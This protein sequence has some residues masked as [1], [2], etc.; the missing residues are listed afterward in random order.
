MHGKAEAE[1]NQYGKTSIT[2]AELEKYKAGTEM[3][4]QSFNWKDFI[5]KKNS[6]LN[7]VNLNMTGG[8]DKINYYIS[9]THLQPE[10]GAG[11][12]IYIQENQHSE[13]C[14]C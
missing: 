7:S 13:Q 12:G 10:L 3:G 1:M 9:G 2:Q 14:R 4:Y 6:P 8:S 11:P 5:V